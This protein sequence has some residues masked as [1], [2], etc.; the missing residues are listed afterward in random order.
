MEA[1]SV[2]GFRAIRPLAFTPKMGTVALKRPGF[3]RHSPS[4]GNSPFSS[5]NQLG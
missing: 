4:F 3:P 1:P 5:H 2:E